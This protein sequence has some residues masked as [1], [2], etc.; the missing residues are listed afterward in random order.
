MPT[1]GEFGPRGGSS[2]IVEDHQELATRSVS[3]CVMRVRAATLR[4][5]AP[6]HSQLKLSDGVNPLDDGA[7]ADSVTVTDLTYEE[8][9]FDAGA[10]YKGLFVPVR[11][12]GPALVELRATGPLKSTPSW[13]TGFS[14][15]SWAR[16]R[17][18][19]L[20]PTRAPATSRIV[21]APP[22]ETG[23][24]CELLSVR[25]AAACGS[26]FTIHVEKESDGSSFGYYTAGQTGTTMSVG[27]DFLL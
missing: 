8:V 19:K 3:P 24:W 13:T 25:H 27:V 4:W 26:I 23:R 2:A 21:Q 6:K 9:A 17:S 16:C 22:W 18:E 7:L 12:R 10:K 1:T 15:R 14:M 5:P 11:V 20:M